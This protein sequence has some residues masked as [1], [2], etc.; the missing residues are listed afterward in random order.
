[1]K[2]FKENAFVWRTQPPN[3]L[4]EGTTKLKLK[5]QQHNNE[6]TI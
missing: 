3:W 2:N 1:M 6:T 5:K 4:K